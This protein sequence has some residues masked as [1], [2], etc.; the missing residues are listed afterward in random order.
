[1]A[2]DRQGVTDVFTSPEV[3]KTIEE[4]NIRLIN[5][6]QLTKSLP[7]AEAA[8]KMQKAMDKY[9]KAVADA[10]QDLHSVMVLQHG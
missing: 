2:V 7:R 6:N 8:P 4:N 9:L 10:K 1:M 3:R 5:F